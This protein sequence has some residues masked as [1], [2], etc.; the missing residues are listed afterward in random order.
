[1]ADIVFFDFLP[2]G[3]VIVAVI[4]LPAVCCCVVVGLS[5]FDAPGALSIVHVF[6]V[7]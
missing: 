3:T 5:M 4:E 1:M 6:G 7:G 2:L